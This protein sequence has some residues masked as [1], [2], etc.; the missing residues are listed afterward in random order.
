MCSYFLIK[1]DQPQNKFLIIDEN[2]CC[3]MSIHGLMIVSIELIEQRM[4]E[5]RGRV[6]VR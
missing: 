2:V 1:L 4:V 3:F 5:K 6:S